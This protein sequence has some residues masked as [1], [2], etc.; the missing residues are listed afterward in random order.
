M[1]V[2]SCNDKIV[3]DILYFKVLNQSHALQKAYK[4]KYSE[5]IKNFFEKELPGLLEEYLE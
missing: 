4:E 2:I 1:K 3:K 5:F